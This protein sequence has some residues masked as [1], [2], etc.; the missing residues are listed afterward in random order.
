MTAPTRDQ[1][2]AWAREAGFDPGTPAVVDWLSRFAALVASA[3]L[4]KARQFVVDQSIAA[5]TE[6]RDTWKAR[7]EFSYRQ[8]D[9]LTRQLA[10]SQA[11]EAAAVAAEREACAKVCDKEAVRIVIDSPEERAYNNAVSDCAAAIRAR[12][13]K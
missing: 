8:R 1:V 6:D 7:A 11:R 10:E 4:A 2:I 9:E 3:E 5:L 13:G 12:G